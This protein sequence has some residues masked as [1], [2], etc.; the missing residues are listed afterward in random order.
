MYAL[1]ICSSS[2]SAMSEKPIS[3]RKLKASILTVGWRLT[4]SLMGPEAN[5]IIKTAM[6]TAVIIT[7]SWLAMPTAVMTESSEKTMSSK[8]I[9]VMTLGNEAWTVAEACA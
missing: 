4:K 7:H 6:I 8:M 9:C 2:P 3:N 1:G 5:N